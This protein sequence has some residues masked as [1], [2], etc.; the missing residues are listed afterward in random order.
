MKTYSFYEP[1]TGLFT[2]RQ[3]SGPEETVEA[4]TPAGTVAI[5]GQHDW[6]RVRFN[7]AT[8][9]IE[10]YQP[11]SPPSTEWATYAWDAEAWTW[12]ASPTEAAVARDV[13][14]ERDRRLAACDWVVAR[15]TERGEPVPA[16]WVAYREALRDVPA[17]PGFPTSVTW[18]AIPN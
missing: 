5:E 14:A 17:Q 12:V 10:P 11:P 7:L 9:E 1:D 8:Q 13:R 4:N 15:A 6:R 3:F 18:P 2:P 16:A